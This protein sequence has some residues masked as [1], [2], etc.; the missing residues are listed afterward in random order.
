MPR[1]PTRER[2]GTP[3]DLKPIG[4]SG[5]N[6]NDDPAM[7]APGEMR[8]ARSVDTSRGVYARVMG[9]AKVA[10]LADQG[11]TYGAKVFGED[12]KYATFSPPAIGPGGFIVLWHFKAVRAADVRW[13]WDSQ[14]PSSERV[15]WASL[16]G[17]SGLLQVYVMWSTGTTSIIDVPGLPD[18]SEQHAALVFDPQ[19]GTLALYLNGEAQADVITGLNANAKPIQSTT[20]P[21]Y[22][23]LSYNAG[24]ASVSSGSGFLGALDSFTIMSTAGVDITDEDLTANP[25]RYSLLSV[26][27]RWAYQDWPWPASPMV[28]CHYGMDEASAGTGPMYDS[29]NAQ[30]HG[31]YFGSP[32]NADRVARRAQNGNWVGCVR[33]AAVGS[34][35][36]ARVN[37]V[38]ARGEHYYESLRTGV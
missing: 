38:A 8:Q 35:E 24:M 5:L 23:G 4:V 33:H 14:Q 1:T 36:N 12:T 29:S 27:R 26:I 7:L 15:I 13:L 22:M 10:R 17:T 16:D 11:A 19:A 28:L 6:L 31:T 30:R 20:T 21:W 2:A 9:D 18:G 3:I 37:L 25:P 34:L 32:T